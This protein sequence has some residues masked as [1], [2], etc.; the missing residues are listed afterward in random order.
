MPVHLRIQLLASHLQ[1]IPAV[2][3]SAAVYLVIR[4]FSS[5]PIC[6]PVR[7]SG[8]SHLSDFPS[9]IILQYSQ[10]KHSRLPASQSQCSA[11]SQSAVVSLTANQSECVSAVI[12]LLNVCMTVCVQMTKIRLSQ[13]R[14]REKCRLM[15]SAV[16]LRANCV[17]RPD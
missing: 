10:P 14:E 17:S 12:G 8:F 6:Q 3:Q 5:V 16:A 7:C 15:A 4:P 2:S 11:V 1:C 9:M 13:N